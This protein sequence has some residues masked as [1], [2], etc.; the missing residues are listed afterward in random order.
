MFKS[1]QTKIIIILIVISLIMMIGTGL[2]YISSLE[3]TKENVKEQRQI[4]DNIERT[5]TTIII[6]SVSYAIIRN[7]CNCVFF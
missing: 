6:V 3:K 5:K 2:F 7:C 4:E 1:I